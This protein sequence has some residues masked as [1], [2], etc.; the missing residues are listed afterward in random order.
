MKPKK[1]N[2]KVT[3]HSKMD[4]HVGYHLNI[5]IDNNAPFTVSKRYSELKH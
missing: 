1:F 3:N 4:G 2:V 5:Q